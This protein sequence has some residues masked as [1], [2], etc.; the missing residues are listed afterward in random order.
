M[1]TMQEEIGVVTQTE[2]IMAKVRVQRSE[3]VCEHCTA[4]GSCEI[5]EKGVEMEAL[6]PVR[7]KVGQT[8]K[9]V[10]KPQAYL[11][12]TIVVYGLP[13]FAIIAGAV[14][15]SHIGKLYFSSLSPDI[16]AAIFGFGAL[17]ITVLFVRM[18]AGRVEKKGEYKPVIEEILQ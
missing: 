13:L 9:I 12:W 11:K 7:A 16:V 3:S 8:V 6:N 17:V 1:S 2:G 10:M 15:G 4:Q 14:L 5:E 18:L